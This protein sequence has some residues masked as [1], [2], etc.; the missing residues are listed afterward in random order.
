MME[1]RPD[2]PRRLA[3]ALRDG[4]D[5]QVGIE[6]QHHD[7][8]MV[9][10][11]PLER[12]GKRVALGRPLRGVGDRG[13]PRQLRPQRHAP[14]HPSPAHP[15]A[16]RI[17]HDA[18]EPGIEAGRVAQRPEGRP[19]AHDRVV[20]RV[21][22]FDRIAQ[23]HRRQAV[24]GVEAP[25]HQPPEQLVIGGRGHGHARRR[26]GLDGHQQ[27]SSDPVH[28]HPDASVPRNVR[29]GAPGGHD[30]G[31]RPGATRPMM[32]SPRYA[33]TSPRV[34]RPMSDASTNRRNP[35]AI[36]PAIPV[37]SVVNGEGTSDTPTMVAKPCACSRPSRRARIACA[38]AP[39]AIDR[40]RA[41]SS[42]WCRAAP[43]RADAAATY[44]DI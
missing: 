30:G 38:R 44:S 39:D 41:G 16:T 11:Q 6:A 24:R 9:R 18:L 32:A 14:P 23:H 42:A 25:R 8:P 20:G 1:S 27:G 36:A 40:R 15:V 33:R 21:L 34:I 37:A 17:D 26:D 43:S 5:G 35:N 12:A 2:G 7:H 10:R 13:Q 3:E 28:A 22:G 29:S 4:L 19:R 31:R